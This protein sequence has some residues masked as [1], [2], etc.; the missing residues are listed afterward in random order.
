MGSHIILWIRI[1]IGNW[2]WALK[3]AI[4]R[5]NL[6]KLLDY[7]E[8]R[9]ALYRAACSR[10]RALS[11]LPACPAWGA[12]PAARWAALAPAA[13]SATAATTRSI[14]PATQV[15]PSKPRL[16]S[17]TRAC[18]PSPAPLYRHAAG[19]QLRC[20]VRR[21]TR[22]A[23]G[24]EPSQEGGVG[25]QE[26]RLPGEGGPAVSR[27]HRGFGARITAQAVWRAARHD[28][29]RGLQYAW[30]GDDVLDQSDCSYA[31][32]GW[33]LLHGCSVSTLSTMLHAGASDYFASRSSYAA[34][35][36]PRN[37]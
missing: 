3:S 13:T 18:R 2:I 23:A 37:G 34:T 19:A 30:R 17:L 10:R 7:F 5:H 9:C 12:R 8:Q 22:S 24:R 35:S 31:R 4:G 33:Y 28:C 36:V 21:H 15:R 1:W 14:R 27:R 25:W 6:A 26:T 20:A 11:P 16:S 32:S 29:G